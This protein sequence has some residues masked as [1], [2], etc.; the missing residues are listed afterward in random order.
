M[1]DL[2]QDHLHIQEVKAVAAF[3]SSAEHPPVQFNSDTGQ[4]H[5]L[6]QS[7]PSSPAVEPASVAVEL[8]T[9]EVDHEV[10]CAAVVTRAKNRAKNTIESDPC[11][12]KQ[13]KQLQRKPRKIPQAST[14]SKSKERATHV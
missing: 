3:L 9:R 5:T 13:L 1:Q 8:D 11:I 7:T 4:Y 14:E 6:I 12:M 10:M 2:T